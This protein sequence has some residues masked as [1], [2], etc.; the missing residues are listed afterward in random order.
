MEEFQ[1]A[2]LITDLMPGAPL[3]DGR[4]LRGYF[5]VVTMKSTFAP[6]I[7]AFLTDCATASAPTRGFSCPAI[8]PLICNKALKQVTS[9]EP[10]QAFH[11]DLGGASHSLIRINQLIT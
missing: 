2:E 1:M 6:C 7:S 10:P 8:I 5:A 11:Q 3:R 9:M 4:H